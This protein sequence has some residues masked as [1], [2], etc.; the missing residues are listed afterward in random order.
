MSGKLIKGERNASEGVWRAT[1]PAQG[2][3]FVRVNSAAGQ[4]TLRTIVKQLEDSKCV[5]LNV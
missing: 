3:Y 2:V 1:V 5:M 4:Q